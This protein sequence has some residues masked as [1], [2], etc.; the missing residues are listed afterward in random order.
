MPS[1]CIIGGKMIIEWLKE[2][3][4]DTI[5]YLIAI[6]FFLIGI[7]LLVIIGFTLFYLYHYNVFLIT[8]HKLA[9]IDCANKT[10]CYV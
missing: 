8:Q 6:T 1:G 4:D 3:P 10:G 5:D 7:E 9:I 2:L